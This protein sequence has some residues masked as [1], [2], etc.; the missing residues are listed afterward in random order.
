MGQINVLKNVHYYDDDDELYCEYNV[1][2]EYKGKRFLAIN[3]ATVCSGAWDRKIIGY[4][5]DDFQRFHK[6][7]MEL[8]DFEQTE[9]TEKELIEAAELLL[10]SGK[11]ELC[12]YDDDNIDNK[13]AN[14][15]RKE[16]GLE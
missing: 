9:F 14:E 13:E 7:G 2:F 5:P 12:Y 15:L 3:D 11:D 1:T 10:F 8:V 4:E 6:G 16:M